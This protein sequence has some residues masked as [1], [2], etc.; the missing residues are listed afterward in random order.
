MVEDFQRRRAEV[1][2]EFKLHG[3]PLRGISI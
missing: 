2:V 3:E 1:L